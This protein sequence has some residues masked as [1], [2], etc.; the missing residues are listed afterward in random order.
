M[1]SWRT[2]YKCYFDGGNKDDSAAYDVVS[3]AV[4]SGF[5]QQWDRLELD[6]RKMLLRNHAPFLHTTDLQTGNGPYKAWTKRQ[7]NVFGEDAVEVIDRNVA[8]RKDN[9]NGQ[10]EG[11]VPVVITIDLKDFVAADKAALK[12]ST[13]ANEL[14]LRQALGIAMTIGRSK[15]CTHYQ[16]IFDRNEP[17]YGFVHDLK[18]S[19]NARKEAFLLDAITDLSEV[20]MRRE[21][22][23]QMADI[24]AWTVARS[25]LPSRRNWHSKMLRIDHG[26]E[27][28][29]RLNLVETLPGSQALWERWKIPK[30]R[31][32]R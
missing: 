18:K 13:S 29:D 1:D 12:M 9:P 6:W 31:S 25:A 22:A 2:L 21:A 17:F 16:M 23:L 15:S 19:K 11:I 3:L 4:M 20:D 27:H 14:M 7:C 24:F 30:R 8:H 26:H 32:T 28:Y 10:R 5:P